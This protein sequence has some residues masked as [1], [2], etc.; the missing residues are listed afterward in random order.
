M[1]DKEKFLGFKQEKLQEN[2]QSYGKEVR[3]K[4]GEEIVEAANQKW[5]N[6]SPENVKNMEIAEKEMFAA[7]KIVMD[8][9]D[10][11]SQAAKTVFLNHKQWLSYTSPVY[12][13]EM[14][15]GLGQMYVGDKRFA[16]YYNDRAGAGA[17]NALNDVIQFFAK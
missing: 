2:E 1:T 17:A 7:L 10:Y 16:A 9:K 4:Y 14:H 3:E 6:L 11:Q 8:T 5:L 12:S 13:P 15:K